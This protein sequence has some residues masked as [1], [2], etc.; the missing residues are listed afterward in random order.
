M[1][2]GKRGGE[3]KE[4][5]A[6]G[7]RGVWRYDYLGVRGVMMG[8]RQSAR[9][10]SPLLKFP[11]I[12][13]VLLNRLPAQ[14]PCL[15]TTAGHTCYRVY[16]PVDMA[17]WQHHVALVGRLFEFKD[18]VRLITNNSLPLPVNSGDKDTRK[19]RGA[20]WLKQS[21]SHGLKVDRCDRDSRV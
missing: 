3:E 1:D 7:P 17:T 21:T 9:G 5:Y 19:H 10:P 20:M 11:H 8:R 13:T 6:E 14:C 15:P 12:A 4:I 16:I 2:G 18:F